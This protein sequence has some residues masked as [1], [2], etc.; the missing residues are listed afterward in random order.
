MLKNINR[1]SY[2]L[3]IYLMNDQPTECGLCGARTDF[4]NIEDKIQLHQCLNSNCGYKFITEED[5]EFVELW[6]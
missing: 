6:Q 4:K 5:V 1:N 2:N 3:D